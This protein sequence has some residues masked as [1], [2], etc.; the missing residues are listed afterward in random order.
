[1]VYDIGVK[2]DD[3]QDAKDLIKVLREHYK[4]VSI[5]WTGELFCSIK[6][7]WDYEIRTVYLIIPGYMAKLL[8]R[9]I[10]TTPKRPEHKPHQHVQPQYGTKAKFTEPEDKT[11]LLQPKDITKLQQ[12]IGE[13][14]YYARV[15]G[16][17]L[18]ITLN[19]LEYAQTNGTQENMYATEK[20]MDYCHTHS[21]KKIRY[22]SSQMQ[23]HIHSNVLYLSASEA[24]RRVGGHFFLS[25]HFDPS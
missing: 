12:I 23:L 19:G 2:Y 13:M 7:D 6:I 22:W 11:P 24:R 4:S 1:M 3:K 10:H 8:Q 16:G 14:L 25:Y 18:M 17:T 21:D 20:L 5:D 15:V 9:F